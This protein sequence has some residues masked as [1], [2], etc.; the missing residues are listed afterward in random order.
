MK[1]VVGLLGV[2]AVLGLVAQVSAKGHSFG[3]TDPKAVE[4][5][6]Q[7][8]MPPGFK[9][10]A[11]RL[12]G[13]VFAD[14]HGKTLYKWPI[15]AMR[16]GYA[17]DPKD[18]SVCEDKVTTKT[19]GYMSPYPEGLD[20][21]ELDQRKSCQALWTPVAA[22]AK[23]KPVGDWTV[24]TRGDG[25]KQWAYDHHALYTSYLDHR[26][27]EVNGGTTVYRSGGD[28]P[29]ERTPVGPPADVPPGFSVE[30]TVRGRMLMTDKKMSVYASDHDAEGKSNCDAACEKLWRPLIAPA[31]A[32]GHGD[33]SIINR[34]PSIRQWAFRK[35]P[36]YTYVRDELDA[37]LDGSEELGWHNVYTQLTPTPPKGFSIQETINGDVLADNNGKTIYFY[38]CGDDSADQLSCDT[39]DSPQ[40]YRVAICGGGDAERCRRLWHYVPAAANAKSDNQLWSIVTVDPVTGHEAKPHQAGAL[41]VW[42]YRTRPVYTYEGDAQPGDFTG[43]AKG[44]WQG[45]R[46]G[47]RA[48]WIRSELFT[49]T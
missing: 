20:L 14:S 22:D 45:R 23:A 3:V 28:T 36:L 32:Q 12:E 8:P 7:V 4:A 13:P 47:F 15:E 29:A 43:H 38:T 37:S 24:I 10:V 9:V 17:G 46:N 25:T 19:G 39:L 1:P 11:T 49:R 21:P 5:F 18:K 27:G 31:G 33:W 41:R 30:S 6:V 34:S 44:E 2:V 26:P 42:A 35:T 48:F 16:Q 40:E